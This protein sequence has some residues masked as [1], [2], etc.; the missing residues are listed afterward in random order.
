MVISVYANVIIRILLV[1]DEQALC[2]MF[3][4]DVGIYAFFT[5]SYV[6]LCVITE[7]VETITII[8]WK[9]CNE[10]KWELRGSER[11]QGRI[12]GQI[13]EREQGNGCY[14]NYYLAEKYV[15]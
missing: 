2:N 9:V 7:L 6:R 4:D 14:A 8:K 3:R 11:Q 15:L 10:K 1:Y 13:I 12:W 5:F